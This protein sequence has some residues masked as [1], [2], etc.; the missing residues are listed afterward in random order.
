MRAR[1]SNGSLAGRHLESSSLRHVLLLSVVLAAGCTSQPEEPETVYDPCSPLTLS[2]SSSATAAERRGVEEAI[3]AWDARLP[4]QMVIGD[5][6][7]S[8]SVLPI[9]FVDASAFRAVYWDGP[10]YISIARKRLAESEYGLA[11]A[12]EMGH[13]FGLM[14]VTPDERSSV[15][16]VGNLE[17]APTEM[18]AE[19]LIARWESCSPV[20]GGAPAP[21]A[22]R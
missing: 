15:M 14:H 17:I 8:S 7:Q 4:V 12:H 19:E 10:G 1:S 16:N 13:A 9:H 3:A 18:D 22:R 2:L 21:S 11:V 5:G 20:A 6:E